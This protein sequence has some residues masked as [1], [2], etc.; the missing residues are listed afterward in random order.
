MFYPKLRDTATMR[1][2]W[3]IV[4]VEGVE[5]VV[6]CESRNGHHGYGRIG[7]ASAVWLMMHFS[8]VHPQ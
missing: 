3:D 4:V 6:N 7:F 5:S 1:D 2:F 8:F